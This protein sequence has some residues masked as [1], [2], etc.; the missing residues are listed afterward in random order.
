MLLNGHDYRRLSDDTVTR[1]KFFNTQ[2]VRDNHTPA[3]LV[4]PLTR[5][6]RTEP[7]EVDN[8]DV[9][10][11]GDLLLGREGPITLAVITQHLRE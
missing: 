2:I 6:I 11:H 7:F 3:V 9:G 8:Q 4:E 10:Q 1:T 5:H